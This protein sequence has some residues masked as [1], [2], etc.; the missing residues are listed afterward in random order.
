MAERPKTTEE[1]LAAPDAFKAACAR[2]T[3]TFQ[4]IE[5]VRSVGYGLK[6][7]GGQFGTEL[8]IIVFVREK[9]PVEALAP[10]ERVPPVFEGYRTDVRVVPLR[11]TGACDNTTK[12]STIQ[13]GIQIANAGEQV[14]NT[15]F[16][17][18]GTLGCVV[19]RRN[20]AG[21]ENVYVLSAAHVLYA[22][23]HGAKD[24]I[25]HPDSGGETLG[26]IL[27]GGAFRNIS[28]TPGGG[29]AAIDTFSDCAIARLDLDSTCCGSTCTQD[30]T[31]YA[32]SIIDLVDV[33]PTEA[34]AGA[35]QH[36]ANCITDVRNV[37]GDLA[38]ARGEVVT[39]VGRTTG[40]TQG[41][42]VG[43]TVP[44][45][46]P[47]PFNPTGPHVHCANCIEIAFDPAQLN[48][49]N[50]AYF[51]EHGDSGSL[52]LDAQNRAVGLLFGGPEANK[53]PPD[54]PGTSSTACHIVPVLDH[55]GICIP[56]KAGATK[57]GSALATDGSGL[58][59][60]PLAP[61]QST[62]PVGQIV[63]TA[64]GAAPG[65]D[66]QT[67]PTVTAPVPVNEEEVRR[68]RAHLEEF[69][70][71][72]IGPPL[73][74][75]FGEVRKEIGYLIR[76]VRPVKAAWARH[77]GP[78]YFAHILN[79]IAGHTPTIPHEVKGVTRRALLMRMREVLSIHGSNPLNCAL[80]EYGDEV[81]AMLT[82][83]GCDSV[84]DCIAWI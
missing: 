49:Q 59:P 80:A 6:Q 27:D 66:P 25:Y 48:C 24:N 5:G 12:Y 1:I 23:G 67:L 9:K 26:P 15:I 10:A 46:M 55:L 69:R 62:L 43:V 83:E 2:A 65:G 79:H 13:G 52:V 44:V 63:F 74:E 58:A 37:I 20:D 68:M 22:K 51:S 47:D 45:D 81:L 11:R 28:W 77:Q 21:R 41:T 72:R 53:V 71:T 18:A 60:I 70:K 76:N 17:E 64:D 7:T 50:H 19:R 32:E 8:A 16:G 31:A 40:K 35:S 29:V 73:H 33:T 14:G 42:C 61:A 38:F 3:A 56:C 75:V 36:V 82:F 30:K 78:A 4:K 54:P 34:G 39:K 84:A 57:H